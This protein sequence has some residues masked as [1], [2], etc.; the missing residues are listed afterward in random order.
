MTLGK[1]FIL[2]LNDCAVGWFAAGDFQLAG[3]G[4]EGAE[5]LIEVGADEC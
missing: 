4:A 3:A 2:G 1:Q 5:D